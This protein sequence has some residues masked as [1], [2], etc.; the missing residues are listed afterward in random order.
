MADLL[1]LIWFDRN[2]K[3]L[4]T[5]R[6][7]QKFAFVMYAFSCISLGYTALVY[8]PLRFGADRW[9]NSSTPVIFFALFILMG[10]QFVLS[11]KMM[12]QEKYKKVIWI[13]VALLALVAVLMF[14][15]MYVAYLL[16]VR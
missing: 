11:G 16:A 4:Y 10:V 2:F 15:A 1:A 5:I 3:G 12:T 8:S 6:M 14:P 13:S 9:E 7:L